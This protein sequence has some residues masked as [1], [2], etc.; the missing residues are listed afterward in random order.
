MQS[1]G[2]QFN[3]FCLIR[4]C[5]SD[6]A[7]LI[8]VI[9]HLTPQEKS[10]LLWLDPCISMSVSICP[11]SSVKTT[12]THIT[13]ELSWPRGTCVQNKNQIF[14]L[15]FPVNICTLLSVYCHDS[16]HSSTDGRN[17]RFKNC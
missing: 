10:G 5:N 3:A 11:W 8:N 7:A 1:F 17:G 9:L 16:L 4:V 2:V 15:N 14:Q 6:Y 12:I 13:E